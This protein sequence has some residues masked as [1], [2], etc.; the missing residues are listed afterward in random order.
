MEDRYEW[1]KGRIFTVK[2]T[3]TDE[4]V[5]TLETLNALNEENERLK[6]SQKQLAIEELN[7]LKLLLE[8]EY[9]EHPVVYK[10][11]QIL[12]L[13]KQLEASENKREYLFSSNCDYVSQIAELQKQLEEKEKIIQ[14]RQENI[15]LK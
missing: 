14:T 1:I 2:D 4:V 15:K 9:N 3:K 11:Q 5:G 6:Q 8:E 12:E 7:K 10:D 13:Q